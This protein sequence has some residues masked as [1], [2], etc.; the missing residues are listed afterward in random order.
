M[1]FSHVPAA[2][3][4]TGW[5]PIRNPIA[6][7]SYPI[8]PISKD[9]SIA[10]SF[11]PLSATICVAS[12]PREKVQSIPLL[13]SPAPPFHTLAAAV[14]QATCHGDIPFGTM[15]YVIEFPAWRMQGQPAPASP[16][17]QT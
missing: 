11:C 12:E 2:H 15:W 14:T 1:S 13:T 4:L 9:V 8:C 10:S 6:A 3:P 5:S 7:G 16:N 17:F